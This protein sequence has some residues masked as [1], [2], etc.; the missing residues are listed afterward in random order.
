[1][2]RLEATLR[3][4]LIA[5]LFGTI[6]YGVTVW[7]IAPLGLVAIAATAELAV[8]PYAANAADRLLLACGAV[9]TTLILIGLALN[10]TPWGLT[11]TTW[12]VA[13]LIVSIGVLSWRRTI[14][15]SITSIASRWAAAR[16]YS[17]WI[18]AASLILVAAVILA[19]AGVRIWDRKP[20]LAFSVV[21]RDNNSVV[22]EIEAT[23]IT[24]EYQIIATSPAPQALQYSS[25]P[26]T[27]KADGNGRQIRARV[28]LN[29]AGTW[30][31]DLESAYNDT[32][33]RWLRVDLN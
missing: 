1:V 21:S 30:T 23:S 5:S 25:G 8:R 18:A 28:P 2:H 12:N 10:L 24:G 29:V 7:I 26:L 19:L 22:V 6:M 9:V 13:W 32:V 20:V 31:I 27:I 16:S 4:T 15:T 11:K 17:V 33:V 3:V 14:A